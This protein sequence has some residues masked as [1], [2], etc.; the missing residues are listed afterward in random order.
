MIRA[1]A[2]A[3][4]GIMVKTGAKKRDRANIPAVDRAVR[5][6]L[7][8]SATPEADSTKVV[9]VEVP[10]QAPAKVPTASAIR[11]LPTLGNFPS[12][13]SIPALEAT[14]ARVPT[15]SKIS[16]KRKVKTTMSIS[17]EKI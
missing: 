6:V 4:V 16:T 5:P 8:P 12:L 9:T 2:V 13:S 7:P 1:G 14:P 11:A 3:A 10:R 17:N 15:V